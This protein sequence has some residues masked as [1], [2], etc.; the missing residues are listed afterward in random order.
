MCFGN[1]RG[2]LFCLE[3]HSGT[4][5]G[6]GEGLDFKDVKGCF[7]TQLLAMKILSEKSEEFEMDW[8][9]I[10]WRDCL[11]KVFEEEESE[12]SD[13]DYFKTSFKI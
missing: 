9:C 3:I 10:V 4:L 8:K 7:I 1:C 12:R 6:E 2:F 11:D 13:M 5:S